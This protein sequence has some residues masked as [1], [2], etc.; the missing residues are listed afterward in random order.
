[1]NAPLGAALGRWLLALQPFSEN[2]ELSHYTDT[3]NE[4]SVRVTGR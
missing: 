4:V 2:R 3:V 1:M